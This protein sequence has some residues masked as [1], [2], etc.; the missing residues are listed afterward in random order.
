MLL[1]EIGWVFEEKSLCKVGPLCRI[2]SMVKMYLGRFRPVLNQRVCSRYHLKERKTSFKMMYDSVWLS[3]WDESC[4]L[5]K[6]RSWGPGRWLWSAI[7]AWR[8]IWFT[9]L[10]HHLNQFKTSYLTIY[11]AL[12]LVEYTKSCMSSSFT[13]VGY[14]RRRSLCHGR[15]SWTLRT[16]LAFK[17]LNCSQ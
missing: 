15:S 8:L 16:I 10:I 12:G 14:R 2:W 9:Q 5:S 1:I 17:V 4:W 6:L 3:F 7:V 11:Y 13:I